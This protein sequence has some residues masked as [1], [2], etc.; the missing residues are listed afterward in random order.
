MREEKRTLEHW[1]QDKMTVTVNHQPC[2]QRIR[3]LESEILEMRKR[4]EWNEDYLHPVHPWC[5]GRQTVFLRMGGGHY[6]IYGCYKCQR[7]FEIDG[8]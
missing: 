6:M 2:Q 4:L 8:E 7:E 1:E 5:G 3:Q